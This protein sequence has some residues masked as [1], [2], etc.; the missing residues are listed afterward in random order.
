MSLRTYRG[1]MISFWRRKGSPLYYG[2][3]ETPSGD[4]IF[5]NAETFSD[6]RGLIDQQI[7]KHYDSLPIKEAKK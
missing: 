6:L 1:Y 7:Q 5:L 2:W 4:H 3:L